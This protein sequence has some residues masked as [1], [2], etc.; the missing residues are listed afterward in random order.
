MQSKVR[1]LQETLKSQK[2]QYMGVEKD[3][4]MVGCTIITIWGIIFVL[5]LDRYVYLI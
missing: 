2:T 4:K 3:A 5:L 1:E